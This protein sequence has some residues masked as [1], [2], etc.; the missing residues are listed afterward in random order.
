VKTFTTSTP[1]GFHF[2][3][4]VQSHGWVALKPFTYDN[5]AHQLGY[6]LALSDGSVWLLAVSQPTANV[7]TLQIAADGGPESLTPAR[8]AEIESALR[9]M[10]R[11]DDDL[12]AFHALCDTEPRLAHVTAAGYGRVLRSPTA[13]EDLVRVIATTNTTWTLTKRM[14][15]RLVDHYGAPHPAHPEQRAFPAP[16]A[17]AVC[18]PADIQALGW[19]YRAA[20]L[21]ENARQ[22]VSAKINLDALVR[23]PESQL[24]TPALRKA[25]LALRG[26]GDY[27]AG[28]LL[29]LFGRYS[30]V[31]VDTAARSVVS[32]LFHAGAPVTDKQVKAALAPYQP[33]AALALYCLLMMD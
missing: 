10:L 11:L 17:I 15:G 5:E 32:R 18:E 22:I 33:Y 23:Q 16:A 8:Q 7:N 28:T 26:V 24:A 25:L 4:T 27:A 14:I 12:T 6:T 20:Y 30:S 29:L 3:Q 31:P 2:W 9:W 13:W 1:P 21:V 19:G